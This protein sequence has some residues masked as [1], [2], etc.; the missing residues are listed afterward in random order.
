MLTD[1]ASITF[2]IGGVSSKE[3]GIRVSEFPEFSGA[4]P[5]VTKYAIPGRNGDLTYWDG[6]FKN[7]ESTIKCFVAEFGNVE[8]ILTAVNDWMADCGYKK[9]VLSSEPGRYRLA[10]ITNAAEIAI[11]MG[12]LAPFEI[13]LDCKPQRF[14]DDDTPARF[15]GGSGE[16]YNRTGFPS[17]PLLRCFLVEDVSAAGT[18]YINFKNSNGEYRLLLSATSLS[19]T[20]W[21]D[22][23]LERK[24]AVKDNGEQLSVTTDSTGFPAFCSGKT[25]FSWGNS[26]ASKEWF[27]AIDLYPRWWT[28]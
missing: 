13:K 15:T 5:R 11:R 14:F 26:L 8:R 4:E 27:S 23:D 24:S 3:L 10:R 16:I 17:S 28:L 19:G 12:V 6:S 20:Q 25:A 2:W 7:V 22:V 9:L 1:R 21:V 18:E